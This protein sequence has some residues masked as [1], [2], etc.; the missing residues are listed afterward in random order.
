MQTKY[1]FSKLSKNNQTTIP[2]E[3]RDKLKLKPGDHIEF[4]MKGD[5]ALISEGNSRYEL[6]QWRS[7]QRTLTVGGVTSGFNDGNQFDISFM[8]SESTLFQR[9][10]IGSIHDADL[11]GKPVKV[12]VVKQ[13]TPPPST[14]FASLPAIIFELI[15]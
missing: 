9:F 6:E 2:K 1:Y 10:P 13:V 8:E 12:K 11:D 4:V 7:K 14:Q 3:I 15:E 5:V